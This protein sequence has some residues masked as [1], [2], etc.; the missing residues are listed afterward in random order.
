[1]KCYLS[2]SYTIV[3]V[4]LIDG[5]EKAENAALRELKEETGIEIA[6]SDEEFIF[7][8]SVQDTLGRY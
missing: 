2:N 3:W 6:Q 1:M 7:L 4:G 8:N 5:H